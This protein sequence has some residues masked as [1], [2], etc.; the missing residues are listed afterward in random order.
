MH[1]FKHK[2][3]SELHVDCILT[4]CKIS[5]HKIIPRVLLSLKLCTV[6]LSNCNF[7]C[8]SLALCFSSTSLP[9]N[10]FPSCRIQSVSLA[11]LNRGNEILQSNASD[12]RHFFSI[13][14]DISFFFPFLFF[15]SSRRT[16][17]IFLSGINRELHFSFRDNEGL[18]WAGLSRNA[19]IRYERRY[20]MIWNDRDRLFAE[21]KLVVSP[22]LSVYSFV[23]SRALS[24]YLSTHLF[25]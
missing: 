22:P 12:N 4:D 23:S 14:S 20:G 2:Q 3:E 16:L 9:K 11:D 15:P 19:A 1:V 13:R 8:R 25:L 21:W 24:V 5:V 6:T 18:T 10:T 17:L 7:W